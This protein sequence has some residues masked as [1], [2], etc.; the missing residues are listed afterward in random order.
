MTAERTL[1]A[2]SMIDPTDSAGTVGATIRRRLQGVS[3]GRIAIIASAVL[4]QAI[5]ILGFIAMS[6][7][8][9]A[10]GPG[11]VGPDRPPPPA[12]IS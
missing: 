2:D 6:L 3:I 12:R 8:L 5:L 11:A 1:H 7:G 10:D 9:G 4:V